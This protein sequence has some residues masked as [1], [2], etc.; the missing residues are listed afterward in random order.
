ML[1][2]PNGPMPDSERSSRKYRFT[3]NVIASIV[4]AADL[5]CLAIS[6]PMAMGL[7]ATLIGRQYVLDM[8]LTV[9]VIVAVNFLLI[10]LSRD[11]YTHPMGKGQDSDQGVVF[12]FTI[13]AL[14]VFA[15]IWQLGLA[16]LFSSG[17]ALCYAAS[18]L[19]TLFVSRFLVRKLVWHLVQ[20]GYIGQRIVLY[21]ADEHTSGRV[22]RLLELERLPYL[23][24]IGIADGRGKRIARDGPWT[25]PF[26]GDLE[27]L[28]ERVKRGDVDM[29][30]IAL[31]MIGQ[32][33][34]DQITETLQ[35]VSVDICL[36]PREAMDL[37]TQYSMRFIGSLPLFALWQRP[38]R[39]WGHILKALEDR[40]LALAG[41]VVLSPLLA[42]TALAVRFTS[43][44]PILFRQ[45][46]FGFNNVKIEVLK[47]RSMYVDRQDVSG[48]E[49]TRRGDARI[50]PVGRI[51]RRLSIDELPQL[52]NVLTGEMS[53]VGPRPHAT[54]M[55]VGDHY[56]FD[57]VRGYAARHRVKPGITGLA[58]V[59]GL[60]GEI[61][62]IERAKRRVEYDF[63][64][65]E[66]WSLMLDVRIILETCYKLLWDHNAY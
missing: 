49:R 13:A 59:R 26:I 33:R 8:H 18:C 60:R 48:T 51:I 30:I 15:T 40:I 43:P 4:I 1:T 35:S 58:Q 28:L 9:A 46:R 3:S 7:Y 39:D 62:T 42:L 36:M 56:Y 27:A 65:I 55:K 44:G 16:T 31:P 17:L 50:T 41:L 64:Y 45:Q 29:V 52:L 12:E 11:S 61:D 24:V 10:R 34:L 54:T 37:S 63:Y 47:F 5:L 53:I 20:A 22:L 32:A 14:L 66:N 6:V 23:Q 25:V 38:M 57:A 19:L 21:G 2:L